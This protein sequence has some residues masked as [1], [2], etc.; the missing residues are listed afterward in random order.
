MKRALIA[1]VLLAFVACGGGDDPPDQAGPSASI[2][3]TPEPTP[4]VLEDVDTERK[5]AVLGEDVAQVSDMRWDDDDGCPRVVFEF[6]D[7]ISSY[8]VA[9]TDDVSEC[10]SGAT[11]PTDEWD[12]EA[13]LKVRLEPAGGPDPL[14]E[15]GE[16]VYKGPRDI[17]ADGPVLKHI[18]VICDY[19]AVFE[20]IIALD[21]ER[22]FDV[23]AMSDPA[24]LVIDISGG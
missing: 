21:E 4:C 9:Y 24:R 20:W 7:Q 23:V 13:F 12:A 19:E 17:E 14:S 2:A 15:S 3:P 6:R 16:P 11:P 18:K 22:P 8:E 5:A 10:G 1:V